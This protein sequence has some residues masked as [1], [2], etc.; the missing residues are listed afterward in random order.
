MKFRK[1]LSRFQEK[2]KGKL[3]KIGDKPESGG[4]NVGGEGLYRSAL[5]SQSEPG[6][7]VGGGSKGDNTKVGV[8][9]DDQR[10]VDSQSVSRS[11]VGT[12]YDLG[13][14][15][16][17]ADGGETG[18]KRLHPHPHTE[19]EGGSSQERRDVEG[20][21]TDQVDP[22]PQSDIRNRTPTL[23][24]SRGGESESTWV[25]PFQSLPLTD[26]AANKTV[27]D[28]ANVDVTTSKDRSDWKHT[29]SSAAKLFLRTVE[30]A[31][32]A[33]PPLKSVAAGLCAILDNCEV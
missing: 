14:S 33:F 10:P 17:N 1:S 15:D 23:S 26:G 21:K 22:L 3:S 2:V 4:A 31:S 24:I 20:K 25:T 27:P 18:Q 11:M 12:G 30:R 6:I 28:T 8:G 32:D 7:A 9:K 29:A 5:S 16:D 19:L 13:G